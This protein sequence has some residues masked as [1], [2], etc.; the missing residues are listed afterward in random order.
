[1]EHQMPEQEG[2]G[3]A[4][5]PGQW[6][7][8]LGLV[9]IC[10]S[11]F[12]LPL[13]SLT[14]L[15]ITEQGVL[16]VVL[17]ILVS[18]AAGVALLAHARG[19]SM[20]WGLLGLVPYG[21]PLSFLVAT[22]IEAWLSRRAGGPAVSQVAFAIMAMV[23]PLLMV[24]AALPSYL[25]YGKRARQAEARMNLGAIYVAELAFYRTHGRYGTF[26]EIGFSVPGSAHRYTY[27]IDGS[28]RPGTVIPAGNGTAMPDNSRVPAGFGPAGFT[29]TATAD[30]DADP[31]LDQWHVNDAKCCLDRA[32]VSDD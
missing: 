32:D 4:A 3:R 2:P 30:I 8:Q 13:L 21:G 12:V 29:A 31:T 25:N 22:G 23:G 11:L 5:P 10:L 7:Q 26:D 17:L 14:P 28:G 18:G 19:R 24:A 6:V 16:A 20:A 1:M 27:R 9:L 15:D